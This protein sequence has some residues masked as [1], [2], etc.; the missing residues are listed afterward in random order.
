MG[1]G[2]TFE[3]E[4]LI[5][6][7]LVSAVTGR[8]IGEEVFAFGDDLIF[9]SD[10]SEDVIAC[11]RFFGFTPNLAKTFSHGPFRESCGG[12]YFSGRFVRP[13]YLKN[14]V[15]SPEETISFLNGLRRSADGSIGREYL[16]RRGRM[17]LMDGLPTHIRALRGPKDLGD[18]VIHDDDQSLWFTSWRNRK[19]LSGIR[20]IKGYVPAN[21]RK[22]SLQG[23]SDDAILASALYGIGDIGSGWITPRDSVLGYRVGWIAYS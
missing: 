23:F 22:V 8:K 17:A 12:D 9:P 2:F 20:W 19:G 5:F 13:F 1:N 4:T 15:S 21:Y 3:L 10:L 18:A 16:F 14:A 11:L 7:S 6:M